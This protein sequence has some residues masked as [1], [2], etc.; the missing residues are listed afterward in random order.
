M[1][2][3][4]RTRAPAAGRRRPAAAR[5]PVPVAGAPRGA[6]GPACPARPTAGQVWDWAEGAV[7]FGRGP[8]PA[9]FL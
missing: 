2:A 1:A 5:V 4:A 3:T 9:D 8:S 7:L 6:E